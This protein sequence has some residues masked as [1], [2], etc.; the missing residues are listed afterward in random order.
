MKRRDFFAASAAAGLALG[1]TG[2]ARGAQGA[3]GKDLYELRTYSFASAEK[4]EAFA[5]F[6]EDA[7]PAL[8]RA[9]VKPVGV[10]R[11][12][13]EDNPRLKEPEAYLNNLWVLMPHKSLESV[14]TLTERIAN[15]YA[16]DSS[17]ADA[18]L[19]APKSD[20]AYERFE[21][22]L[23]LAFDDIPKLEIHSEKDTRVVQLRIYE[24]HSIERHIKKVEMFNEGGEI[25]IFRKTGMNPVFFGQALIGSLLPN[26]TYML[27]FDDME[28]MEAGWDAFRNHP[29]WNTLKQDPQYKDTVSRITNLVM[30][31]LPAS[32]I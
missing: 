5:A 18:I 14:V 19:M 9:G 1:T 17:D 13:K 22:S 30:R 7:V 27:Q 26:L 28:A 21:S 12:F 11:V 3:G 16:W 23:L 24:S 4:L 32:Q 29:D 25:E 6:L 10:F 2:L 8:N 15:D 31:P 20:K